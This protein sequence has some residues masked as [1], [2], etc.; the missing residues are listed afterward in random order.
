MQTLSLADSCVQLV[1][2]GWTGS[3][4]PSSSDQRE[5]SAQICRFEQVAQS[6]QQPGGRPPP[7]EQ[8]GG[9]RHNGG[10]VRHNVSSAIS[11]G[12]IGCWVPPRLR[13][14]SCLLSCSL[15]R[16]IRF[17]ADLFDVAPMH[18]IAARPPAGASQMDAADTIKVLVQ[19]VQTTRPTSLHVELATQLHLLHRLPTHRVPTSNPSCAARNYA[20]SSAAS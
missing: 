3:T 16:A 4:S 19:G 1:T 2:A 9:G 13:C 12:H 6:S 14:P 5:F 15:S 20:Q 11:I 10:Q 18:P 8:L 7:T 17:G